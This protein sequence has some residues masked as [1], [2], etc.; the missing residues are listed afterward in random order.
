MKL[1]VVL[2]LIVL[3]NSLIFA[4]ILFTGV[5]KSTGNVRAYHLIPESEQIIELSYGNSY[6]PR[7]LNENFIVLNIGNSI[8]KVDKFGENKTYFF[9]GYMPVVSRSGKYVS[10]YS[11]NGITLS[12]S[13][14]KLISKIEVDCWTKVTPIFSYDEKSIFYY[15]H[16]RNAC[17]EFNFDKQTNYL[18]GHFV[19]HPLHSPDGTKLLLNIGKTDSNFKVAIANINWKENEP[20]TYLTS[21]Y[22]NS[23]V[24]I[25]SPSGRYIVYMR[26]LTDKAIDNSDLIPAN[27]ILYDTHTHTK[28]ILAED[29]GF[30][31]GVFPQFSFS[32]DERFFY[33]TSIRKNGTGTIT[34][35]DLTNNQKRILITDNTI[36]ARIPISLVY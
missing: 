29:A 11:K 7:W 33:Y 2:T 28:K 25:W 15:D 18:I 5:D 21:D 1:R 30:T 8:F 32:K 19:F 17:F 10:A 4:Q 14:G 22:E 35:I 26:L 36:D 34:E 20:L 9:E 27:I 24:P 16:T 23:V 13:T 12:D 6:L 3:N 31:E